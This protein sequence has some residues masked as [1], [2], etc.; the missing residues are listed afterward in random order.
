MHNVAPVERIWQLTKDLE[1]AVAVGEWERAAQLADERS[2][3]LMAL[4]APQPQE[5]MARLQAIHEIDNRIV[6]AAQAAQQALGAEYQA[7]MQASRNAGQYL[8]MARY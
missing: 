4:G 1:L 7:S 3:L 5:V 2:P 6:E 8:N